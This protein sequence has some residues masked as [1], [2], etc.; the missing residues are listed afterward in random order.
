M[1]P[2][3]DSRRT[4]FFLPFDPFVHLSFFF[5]RLFSCF[6][7]RP[8]QNFEAVAVQGIKRA[9]ARTLSPAPNDP[10]KLFE[11]PNREKVI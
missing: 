9:L 6:G 3:F 7:T 5:T 2:G 10:L 8:G 11:T 4:H 1:G